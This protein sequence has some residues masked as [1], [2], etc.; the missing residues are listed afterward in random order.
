[1]APP[2]HSGLTSRVIGNTIGQISPGWFFWTAP[3]SD[4]NAW[5]GTTTSPCTCFYGPQPPSADGFISITPRYDDYYLYLSGG[6]PGH[7]RVDYIYS[8]GLYPTEWNAVLSQASTGNRPAMVFI[9]SW[10]EYHEWSTMEPHTDYTD[11][12]ASP[13]YL[14]NLTKTNIATLQN[15]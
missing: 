15:P 13:D 2:R 8:E 10:N 1:M 6:R 14:L 7:M 9:Y 11:P 12:G 3:P 4:F 5:G